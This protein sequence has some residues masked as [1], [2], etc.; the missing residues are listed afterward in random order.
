[1]GASVMIYPSTPAGSEF[2]AHLRG[3]LAS[4]I[5]PEIDLTLKVGVMSAAGLTRPEI[6]AKAR[7]HHPEL[8]D[9]DIKAAMQRL[10]RIA[11]DWRDKP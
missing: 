5:A 8:D 4:V 2:L 3:S 11:T 1:M 7:E 6:L 10:K 9:I